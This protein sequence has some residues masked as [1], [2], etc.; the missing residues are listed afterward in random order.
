MQE[1]IT[2][3]HDKEHIMLEATIDYN[4]PTGTTGVRGVLEVDDLSAHASAFLAAAHAHIEFLLREM[5]RQ[6]ISVDESSP[7]SADRWRNML[8]I[9]SE[10]SYTAGEYD[11]MWSILREPDHCCECEAE[12]SEV[13]P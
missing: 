2:Q 8:N 13:T 5:E 10:K 11:G 4:I 7:L 9:L 12:A 6:F 1:S 3:P